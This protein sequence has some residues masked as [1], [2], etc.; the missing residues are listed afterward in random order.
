MTPRGEFLLLVATFAQTACSE[1]WKVVKRAKD[2]PFPIPGYRPIEDLAIEFVAGQCNEGPEP[3]WIRPQ[4]VEAAA[5]THQAIRD[6][7]GSARTSL[8]G[9]AGTIVE[10]PLQV[11]CERCRALRGDRHAGA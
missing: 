5:D 8:C 9:Q 2:V 4:E 7:S 11:S 1:P 10:H 3:S 6:I